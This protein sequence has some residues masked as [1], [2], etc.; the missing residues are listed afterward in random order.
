MSG[1]LPEEHIDIDYEMDR[2]EYE[3]GLIIDRNQHYQKQICI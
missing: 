2:T 3:I 1:E